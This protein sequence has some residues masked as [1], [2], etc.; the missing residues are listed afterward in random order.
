MVLD[1]LRQ[2]KPGIPEPLLVLTAILLRMDGHP[3][4]D[5]AV[6]D[7]LLQVLAG[8]T[9][10]VRKVADQALLAHVMHNIARG[11]KRPLRFTVGH[12]EEVLKDLPEHLRVDRHLPLQ[13]L[14]LFDGE[15]EL[16]KRLQNIPKD[17][18]FNPQIGADPVVVLD[19]LEETAVQERDLAPEPAVVVL[20]YGAVF[21]KR[22]IEERFEDVVEETLV[23]Y[24]LPVIQ[25]AHEIL[26]PR[27]PL[28]EPPGRG[29]LPHPEPPL[30]LEEIEE[31]DLTEEF[32]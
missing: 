14:I 1:G 5:V 16:V 25:A 32:L 23:R 15:V 12:V 2:G 13:G 27:T 8:D 29:V 4:G 21:S 19:R 7:E 18:V 11:V 24:N 3:E 30:L 6:P 9:R 31:D 28:L 22:L 10:V 20:V 17:L 26:R